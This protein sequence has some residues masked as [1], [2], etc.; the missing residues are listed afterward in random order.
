VVR[1]F[2]PMLAETLALGGTAEG[3]PVL[4]A[5]RRLPELAGRKKIRAGEVDTTLVTGSW[6]RLVFAPGLEPGT[7]DWKAYTFCVLE[8]LHRLLRRRDIYA[9][10]SVRWADPR[11]R[12]L[13]GQAWAAA[14]LSVLTSLRLPEQPS[15]HLAELGGALDAAYR[16][17]AAGLPA[18]TAVSITDGKLHLA[19]LGPAP[20]PA[21]LVA[22][23]AACERMLPRVDLP[24]CCWRSTPRP[25]SWT[26]SPTSLA[27]SP[28]WTTCR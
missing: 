22:L 15:E 7:V 3:G 10:G 1:L 2:L 9:D 12:L 20:E 27:A 16:G 4:A 17:V 24:R 21:S 13:T 18:N 11:A 23:R 6:R 5:L 28:A 19:K 26:S 8:R 25:G 14:R